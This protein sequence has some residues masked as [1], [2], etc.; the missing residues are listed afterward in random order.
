MKYAHFGK[1]VFTKF[2]IDKSPEDYG[3]FMQLLAISTSRFWLKFFV[4]TENV[5]FKIFI[6]MHIFVR[7]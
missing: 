3:V 6:V 7:N 4:L 1:I 2:T 5:P